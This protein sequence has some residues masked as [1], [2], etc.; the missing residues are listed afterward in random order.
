[1]NIMP[2]FAPAI[3]RWRPSLQTLV[4]VPR[5]PAMTAFGNIALFVALGD[6]LTKQ[7]AFTLLPTEGA[8]L[9]VFGD[10]LRL[11]PV[12]NDQAAFGVGLGAY[13][14][15]INLAV[16]LATI[17]LIMA[18][19]RELAAIDPWAPRILGLIAG[20]AGGNAISLLISPGGVPDFIAFATRDGGELVMN[21]ADVAA[22]LGVALTARLVYSIVRAMRA[23]SQLIERARSR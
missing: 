15:H 8:S 17:G 3:R 23:R 7:L 10:D 6:T 11:V 9:G 14:W 18:V 19:C 13:T 22:Y 21:F 12:L 20:A 5:E 4:V 2:A 16:T 1:M